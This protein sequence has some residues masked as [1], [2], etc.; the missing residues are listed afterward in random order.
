MFNMARLCVA[1]SLLLLTA[2]GFHLRGTTPFP[3]SELALVDAASST[4]VFTELGRALLDVGIDINDSAPLVLQLHG[5]TSGKRV[6]SVTTEGRAREYGLRYVLRF[7]LR[8]EDGGVWLDN[9]QVEASRDL[10]FDES[11]VLATTAEEA[12]LKSE[13]RREAVDKVLRILQHAKP[14]ARKAD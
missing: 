6:L 12:Q 2:C 8:H 10:R 3:M 1:L 7:S 11:A 4:D 9:E 14:P 5:E 13:M